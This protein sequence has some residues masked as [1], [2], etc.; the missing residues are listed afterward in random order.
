MEA[1]HDVRIAPPILHALAY[2]SGAWHGRVQDTQT[3]I[4]SAWIVNF[5]FNFTSKSA[6]EVQGNGPKLTST[7]S[8][9][10]DREELPSKRARGGEIQKSSSRKA[11]GAV[12]FPFIS[13]NPRSWTQRL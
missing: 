5:F 1:V 2:K 13:A 9:E 4:S 10:E 7:S 8:E 12:H 6:N 3:A 11:D